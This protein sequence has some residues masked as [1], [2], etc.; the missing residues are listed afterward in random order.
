MESG[1]QRILS[2]WIVV[3]ALG[4]VGAV[5]GLAFSA[6]HPPRYEAKAVLGVSIS[7]AITE[8]L[9]LV[10]EDRALNRASG[11]I[12]SDGVLSQVLE[13]VPASVRQAQ[14]WQGPSDL[15]KSLRLDPRLAQWELVAI[16]EDP[17]LAAMVSQLWAEAAI[18]ALDEAARHAWRAAA[19]IGEKLDLNCNRVEVLQNAT[20]VPLWDCSV[21]PPLTD[22][23]AIEDG[24]VQETALSRGVVPDLTYELLQ[25]AEPPAEPVLWSRGPLVLAGALMGVILGG[26][27]ALALP[28][29]RVSAP[30]SSSRDDPVRE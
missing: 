6:T 25:A 11:I 22:P 4:V 17:T 10:V 27:V 3:I 20:P 5:I 19:L 2:R 26:A 14:G 15:R 18:D 9:E 13:A 1:F 8:S 24:L 29:R 23:K 12:Q 30:V 28:E 7:Y 16:D 21:E